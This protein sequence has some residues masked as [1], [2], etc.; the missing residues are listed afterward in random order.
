MPPLRYLYSQQPVSFCLYKPFP[1]ILRQTQVYCAVIFYDSAFISLNTSATVFA[2]NAETLFSF[3]VHRCKSCRAASQRHTGLVQMAVGYKASQ[4]IPGAS[5]PC[6]NR[7]PLARS[8][9]RVTFRGRCCPSQVS[10]LD[11]DKL[12]IFVCLFFPPSGTLSYQPKKRERLELKSNWII[13]M[14]YSKKSRFAHPKAIKC[15]QQFKV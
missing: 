9:Y 1:G 6:P 13:S 7:V 3:L 11:W 5:G 2:N 12:C 15:S 14:N 8:H 10:P 4:C